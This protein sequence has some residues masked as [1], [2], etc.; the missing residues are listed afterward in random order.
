[1]TA[2][3]AGRRARYSATGGKDSAGVAIR[4]LGTAGAAAWMIAPQMCFLDR[5]I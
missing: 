1:V 2:G 4:E 3:L 5:F